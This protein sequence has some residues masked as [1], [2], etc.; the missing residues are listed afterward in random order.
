[1]NKEGKIWG[2]NILLFNNGVIQINQIFIK[3]GGRCSKHLHQHKNNIFFVQK[4][5]LII[6]E[7]K[8][9]GLV[10]ITILKD[11][12]MS[13]IKPGIYHRFTAKEDTSAI[14]IYYLQINEHDIIREDIGS[15]V[16]E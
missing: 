14:E 11:E 2:E 3:K 10:D 8:P 16:N 12:Q 6:E 5:E 15:I 13:E 4:G 9:N 7:W 1:M